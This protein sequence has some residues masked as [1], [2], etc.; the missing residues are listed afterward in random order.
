MFWLRGYARKR[1]RFSSLGFGA[2]IAAVFWNESRETLARDELERLQLDRLRRLLERLAADVP[3]YRNALD[4]IGPLNRLDDLASLP[5]TTKQALREHYPFGLLAAPLE[6]IVRVHASS[7]TTGK[8][9]V[10]AYTEGDMS[11]W[12]ELMA[13][14]L[15]SG[16]VTSKDIVHNAYGYG[17]FTGGLGFG[18]G[19]ETVGAT[20][21]PASAGQTER[22]LMLM[23]DFGATVLCATPSYTL[24]LA[25]TME[26]QRLDR[27]R[28]ELRVGFFGAEPWTEAMRSEIEARLGIEAYDTYGLSE[29]IGPGVA[30]ECSQHRGLHVFEDHF[31]VEVIEPET[32]RPLADDAEGEL[33]VTTLT[34]E[35][36]P[37][38]RYRTRDRVRLYREPCACGRSFV[39]MSR[40]L[41]RTDDMLIVRGVNVFPAQVEEALLSVDGLA[42]HYLI[43][44]DRQEG[45]L[46]DLEIWVEPAN[47]A[48]EHALER[49]EHRAKKKVEETLGIRVSV[50]VVPPKE[51][52]RS[53][54]K[55]VRV[56]DR[57]RI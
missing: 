52:A 36:L 8:P 39:R 44:V 9:T 37:L 57:R 54:G 4:G 41:G 17:L 31:L 23:E 6:R 46:D 40:V 42:P 50:R 26:E 10:V 7:G 45:R 55:A 22:H 3:F 5:F 51:I 14:V 1:S 27:S 19:S 15:T 35:A 13:R 11:L 28:L 25:E 47:G 2:N 21:V 53:Q 18:L 29:I 30:S 33:V 12:G 56:I 38:L 32:G 49:I 20:T 24:V 43:L 16:G 34:K 48:S